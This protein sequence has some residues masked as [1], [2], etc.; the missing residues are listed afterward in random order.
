[1]IFL[2]CHFPRLLLNFIEQR[3][4]EDDVQNFLG[5]ESWFQVVLSLNVFSLT[6]NSS[7]NC[8][9]YFLLWKKFKKVISKIINFENDEGFIETQA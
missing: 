7:V 3:I 4:I 8:L 1:M 5:E 6:F 2:I 9:I